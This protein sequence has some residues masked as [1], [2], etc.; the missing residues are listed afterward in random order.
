M[1]GGQLFVSFDFACTK[2]TSSDSVAWDKIDAVC[3]DTVPSTDISLVNYCVV[4]PEGRFS[5]RIVKVQFV[6]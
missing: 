4:S 6:S 5:C 2:Y 3:E 1:F